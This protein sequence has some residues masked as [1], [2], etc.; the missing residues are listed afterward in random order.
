MTVIETRGTGVTS[1]GYGYYGRI[2]RRLLARVQLLLETGQFPELG[3]DPEQIDLD[4]LERLVKEKVA[5]FPD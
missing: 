3:S 1:T 5:A 4:D 2:N